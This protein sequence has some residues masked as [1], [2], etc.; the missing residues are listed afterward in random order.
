MARAHFH[1]FITPVHPKR[2]PKKTKPPKPIKTNA[3]DEISSS[4]LS[5]KISFWMFT[6]SGSAIS[7]NPAPSNPLPK[8]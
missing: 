4:K 5:T 2:P 7:H 3:G 1:C 8:S 6:E